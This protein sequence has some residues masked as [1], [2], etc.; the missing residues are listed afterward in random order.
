MLVGAD[1]VVVVVV[2]VVASRRSLM[3]SGRGRRRGM[4]KRWWRR[5]GRRGW[6]RTSS[7]WVMS[8]RLSAEKWRNLGMIKRK[9]RN[10]TTNIGESKSYS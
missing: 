7:P 9:M 2:V 3:V 5:R 6:F 10:R 8:R 4:K 1:F